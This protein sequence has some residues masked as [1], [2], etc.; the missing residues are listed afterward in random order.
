MYSKNVKPNSEL[1]FFFSFC[2][3]IIFSNW[4]LNIDSTKEVF[5]RNVDTIESKLIL[6]ITKHGAFILTNA[7]ASMFEKCKKKIC[8]FQVLGNFI[9][10]QNLSLQ[11]GGKIRIQVQD[12]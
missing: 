4:R 7:K 8:K 2:F 3:K 9:F 11:F 6:K 1:W 5:F 10:L 12:T